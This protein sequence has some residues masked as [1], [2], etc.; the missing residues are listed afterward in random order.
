MVVKVEAYLDLEASLESLVL[1]RWKRIQR[2]VIPQIEKAIEAHDLNKVT[3]IVDTIN[4]SLL[5]SGQV[6]QI[7]THLKTGLVFG[8]ALV[9]GTALDLEIVL[10]KDALNLVP[11]ATNQYKIQLDQAMITVRKRFLQLAIKL[12]A[13]LTLEEQ[14]EAEF[15]KGDSTNVQKINPINLR[16]ALQTGAGN[17]GGSMISTASSLQMSRM[18]QYGFTAEASARG[19]T[20]YVV[21]EQLDSRICPVCRRMNGK[22]FEVAPALAKL[23][24]QI[25]I[26]DPTDL[27]ILAPFPKQSKAAVKDLTE[28]TPEQ[29]RAKGWDTPPY[30]PRCRGLLKAVRA[31]KVSQ[32]QPANPLR[33][34]QKIPDKPFTSAS[35]YYVAGDTAVTEEAIMAALPDAD[36]AAIRGIQDLLEGIETTAQRFKNASGVWSAERQLLHRE[37][38][39]KIILGYNDKVKG[40][41][42]NRSNIGADGLSKHKATGGETPVY[43]VL[44]GRGGS[45]KS[46]LTS[47]D[48]PVNGSRNLVL[49]SDA[50][51]Q[52]MPEFKGWN[53]F[54]LHE[55]SSYLFDE[56]SK[57][58][59]RMNLNVV[60]DMTLKSSSSAI[61]RVAQFTKGSLQNPTGYQVEGYYMYLPRHEAA[62]RA[63]DRALGPTTRFVPIDVVL[64]NTENEIVFDQLRASFSRWGMWDNFVPRGVD[65]KFVGGDF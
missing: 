54:E 37:I 46:W 1:P 55:E 47:K 12:E 45:G 53:A 14:Q 6:K 30:H 57:I 9:N 43:T 48:G 26:T 10:N 62:A 27:K 35:D 15:N 13:R 59:K 23:D 17:I 63:I 33:P 18:A 22:R 31:P 60:H 44:G 29:L 40:K 64:T 16:S 28:M 49:D 36:A 32:R 25:R 34:G 38:T 7:N 4:T 61:K 50:I 39:R 65:P 52:L 20:H 3:Q 51:K 42:L 19:I 58:A 41:P 5:Y 21:N 11:I 8:G 24:T 56:I 2:R